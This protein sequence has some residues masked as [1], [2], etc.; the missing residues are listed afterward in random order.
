[1]QLGCD[2]HVFASEISPGGALPR[3]PHCMQVAGAETGDVRDK[4]ELE[5]ACSEDLPGFASADQTDE[6]EQPKHEPSRWHGGKG[7][8]APL[9]D[10]WHGSAGGGWVHNP[11]RGWR[12]SRGAGEA[13]GEKVVY[14]GGDNISSPCR[15]VGSQQSVL[16]LRFEDLQ[17][18][19]L[20]NPAKVSLNIRQ[21]NSTFAVSKTPIYGA[22]FTLSFTW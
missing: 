5:L 15:S 9:G 11:V 3:F 4:L 1:M 20:Y 7:W 18:D 22:Q 19:K 6:S 16:C 8:W 14:S 13:P 17:T 10:G 2:L 12:Q 21:I